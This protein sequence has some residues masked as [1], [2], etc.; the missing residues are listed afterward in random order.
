MREKKKKN[1]TAIQELWENYKSYNMF[2]ENSGRRRQKGT[3]GMFKAIMTENFPKLMIVTKPH[4][5]EARRTPSRV[6]T[7]E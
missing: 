5:K 7:K 4:M 1:G 3:E 2:N 6:N